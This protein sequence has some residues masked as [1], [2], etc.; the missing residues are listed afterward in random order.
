MQDQPPAR[1]KTYRRELP[2]PD[3]RGRIRVVVGQAKDFEGRIY[4]ARFTVGNAA[5]TA[6]A[7]AMRRLDAIRNLYARQCAELGID[8]WEGWVWCWAARL[9]QAVPLVV[10]GGH[11][12]RTGFA[13]SSEGTAGD[14][15]RAIAQLQ[16]WGTP[17]TIA[18][19]RLETL[20]YAYIRKDMDKQI[21]QAVDKALAEVRETWGDH[22]IDKAGPPSPSQGALGTLFR[23]IDDCIAYTR[24]HGKRDGKGNLAQS[25]RKN[26]ERLE[27]LK[28]HHA[29]LPLWRL[30]LDGIERIAGYWRNR[31]KTKRCGRC[32]A[33]YATMMLQEVWR[34]LDW[35]DKQP[36]FHWTKPKGMDDISRKPVPLP[37]DDGKHETAFHSATKRT[38]TPEQLAII[39]KHA[40]EFERALIGICVNC[41]FGASEVGQWST[42]NYHLFA[43]HPHADKLGFKS[44][45]ADSWVLGKRPKTGIYGEHLLWEEVARAVKPLLDGREVLPVTKHP[46]GKPWYRPHSK[47]AQ[48]QFGNWWAGDNGLLERVRADK[49][50][51]NFPKLPFGSLRDLLPNVLRREFSDEVASLCLQHGKLGDDDL[52]KCYANLP[53]KKLF[54]ATREL[55]A[56]FVPFLSTLAQKTP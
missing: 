14:E 42:K 51:A 21:A 6:P 9:A 16:A 36:R 47:N 50:H 7:D 17:I 45:D 28:E 4:A 54:E 40:D 11:D 20:G 34:L 41:A 10:Y 38:Y 5:D 53:F 39:V 25:P 56:M 18:D 12:P 13:T 46:K 26:V 49:D 52:L 33:R 27:V 19:P 8:Y 35:I 48:S 31:P 3:E 15:L 44:T 23:A 22:A 2:R 29:D 24:E 30:D 37:D 1:P 43:K 55:H 32:S